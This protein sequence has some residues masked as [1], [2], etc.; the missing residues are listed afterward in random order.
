MNIIII[1]SIWVILGKR[2]ISWRNEM[3]PRVFI[4]L[5]VF[6]VCIKALRKWG[7]VCF[8]MFL[9]NDP[10]S[11]CIPKAQRKKLFPTLS[12]QGVRWTV[13]NWRESIFCAN[14]CLYA[15]EIHLHLRNKKE[16]TRKRQDW[17]N[18]YWVFSL[19]FSFTTSCFI[20]SSLKFFFLTWL[21]GNLV[22]ICGTSFIFI[23]IHVSWVLKKIGILNQLPCTRRWLKNVC[24]HCGLFEIFCFLGS[25]IN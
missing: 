8:T 14:V 15:W 23:M 24:A 18:N 3:V 5:C 11:P 17:V 16:E 7:R 22:N 12:Y 6:Y 9:G 20:Q 10:F 21:P 25:A 2:R 13:W 4:R 1:N 19:Y